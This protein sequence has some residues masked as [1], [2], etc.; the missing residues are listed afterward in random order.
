MINVFNTGAQYSKH[1]QRIAWME[2]GREVGS[3]RLVAFYD[4]DRHISQIVRI[5]GWCEDDN[6]AVAGAYLRTEYVRNMIIPG[7]M[8]D[9]LRTAAQ[10]Y[11]MPQA[12]IERTWVLSAYHLPVTVYESLF[13]GEIN[14]VLPLHDGYS[15][16][17]DIV[18]DQA[19]V[20]IR[21]PQPDELTQIGQRIDVNLFAV[22][23][24]AFGMGVQAVKF[25]R[26]A[27]PAPDAFGLNWF[28]EV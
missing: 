28:L 15:L 9:A 27:D 2:I 11:Q 1:G 18:G 22:L 21:V 20:V 17:V 6:A 7:P 26:D 19:G 4:G 12:E 8:E 25:D 23:S 14:G 13:K 10:S 16:M 24:A 3:G 5:P